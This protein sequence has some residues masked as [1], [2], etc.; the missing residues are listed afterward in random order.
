MILSTIT[1]FEYGV[2]CRVSSMLETRKEIDE[3]LSI[4]GKGSSAKRRKALKALHETLG[5][6]SELLAHKLANPDMSE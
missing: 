4:K 2:W 1:L 3:I 6:K 5:K